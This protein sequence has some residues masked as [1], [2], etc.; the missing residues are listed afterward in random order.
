MLIIYFQIIFDFQVRAFKGNYVQQLT[1]K[2]MMLHQT[3]AK[4]T[5]KWLQAWRRGHVRI[6]ENR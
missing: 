1:C 6:V 5:E 4:K 2:S 3:K